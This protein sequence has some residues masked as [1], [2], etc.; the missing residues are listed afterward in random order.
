MII[1]SITVPTQG[2][3]VSIVD[4]YESLVSNVQSLWKFGAELLIQEYL[5]FDY[6]I[7]NYR[8]RW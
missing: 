1:K 4:L 2:I 5:K 7:R 8:G 6:D 3:G